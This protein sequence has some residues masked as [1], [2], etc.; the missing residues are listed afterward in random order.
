MTNIVDTT[1]SGDAT[2]LFPSVTQIGT[3]AGTNGLLLGS[4]ADPVDNHSNLNKPLQDLA[5]RD[6]W[7]RDALDVLGLTP[8]STADEIRVAIG[9]ASGGTDATDTASIA[10]AQTLSRASIAQGR[11]T[12]ATGDPNPT[13]DI[14]GATTLYYTPYNGDLISLWNSAESR[15]DAYAFTERSI[16]LSG[17]AANTNYDCF[18]YDSGGAVTLELVAWATSGAGTS[19]RASAISRRNGI[20]VKTSDN[21]RYLGTIRTTATIGECE[22][23]EAKRLCWN[24]TNQIG[25]IALFKW[26]SLGLASPPEGQLEWTYTTLTWRKA[27]GTD[28]SLLEIVAGLPLLIDVY[29]CNTT[30][31][32]GTTSVGINSATVNSATFCMDGAGGGGNPLTFGQFNGSVPEGYNFLYQ[33]ENAI[34]GSSQFFAVTYYNSQLSIATGIN[35]IF[36]G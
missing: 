4:D 16:S 21:R 35:A 24:V 11:L 2:P 14:T 3:T 36:M 25:K 22:D 20:W 28:D 1:A 6:R 5:R 7:L 19:T 15:W 17:L 12:L 31:G 18:A 9:A 8:D 32:A 26:V 13:T 34:T 23:S 10:T 27:R 33:T 29:S 30:S